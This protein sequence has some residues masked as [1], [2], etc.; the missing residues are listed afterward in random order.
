MPNTPFQNSNLMFY[1]APLA[2]AL[3]HYTLLSKSLGTH[4]YVK[5]PRPGNSEGTFLV[6]ES[7]CHLLL[8]VKGRRNPIKCLAQ[9]HNKRTCR[10]ISILTL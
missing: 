10:P 3:F 9:G 8:P 1:H 6:F 2:P 7:S 4:L 5:V